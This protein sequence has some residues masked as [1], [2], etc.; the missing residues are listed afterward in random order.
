MRLDFPITITPPP[1]TDPSTKK[2]TQ[3]ESITLQDL[4]ITY[5]DSPDQKKLVAR[6]DSLPYVLP[7]VESDQEY[8]NLGDYSSSIREKLVKEKLGSDPAAKIRSLFPP[9]L[10]EFPNGPGTILSQMIK[11]VGVSITPTCKCMKH[12]NEMNTKGVKWCENNTEIIIEW[13]KQECKERNIPFIPTVVRMVVNQ[14]ISK[15]KKH[16]I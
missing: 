14:A 6:I 10:E 4:K 7:L 13:L 5:I 16:V 15:A 11:S 1:Y 3:P 9:T 12:A 8:D 2:I